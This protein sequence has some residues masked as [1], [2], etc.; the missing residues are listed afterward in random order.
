MK[1]LHPGIPIQSRLLKHDPQLFCY[2]LQ[3]LGVD[4]LVLVAIQSHLE[5]V[6]LLILQNGMGVANGG[7]K[8]G[9]V[10]FVFG[11]SFLQGILAAFGI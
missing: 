5:F 9:D 7:E 1:V 10:L 4:L 2:I 8:I 6:S 11:I 3:V